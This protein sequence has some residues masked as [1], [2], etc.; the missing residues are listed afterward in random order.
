MYRPRLVLVKFGGGILMVSDISLALL[1]LQGWDRKP[2]P[3]VSRDAAS[4]RLLAFLQADNVWR[5]DVCV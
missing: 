5:H 1:N 2:Y 4:P 3:K